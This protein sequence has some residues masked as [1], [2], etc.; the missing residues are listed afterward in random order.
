MTDISKFEPIPPEYIDRL[1]KD[2]DE[3]LHLG[4]N[5]TLETIGRLNIPNIK[6][7]A[8]FW[9]S[10]ANRLE[11]EIEEIERI[12]SFLKEGED[13]RREPIYFDFNDRQYWDVRSTSR[14]P[15][16]QFNF[17]PSKNVK[18]ALSPYENDF[19]SKN[20]KILEIGSADATSLYMP[21]G[22][23]SK[24]TVLD[25]SEMMLKRSKIQKKV[26]ADAS[27]PLPFTDDSFSAITSFA[28]ARYFQ[29]I[30][31]TIKEFE[32]IL[33]PAGRF[34]IVDFIFVT[35]FQQKAKSVFNPYQIRLSPEMEGFENV[36]IKQLDAG[37]LHEKEKTA[38]G[39]VAVY[40]API[41]ML[42]ATKK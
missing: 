26:Q 24:I 2:K 19:T 33:K 36:D 41:Y 13:P 30:P 9:N 29:D 22:S 10:Q 18:E 12:N 28:S 37:K 15:D 31:L 8:E 23:L 14:N 1:R 38:I 21:E 5:Q 25:I 16:E 32:R 6:G 4:D 17:L 34:V 3:A 27:E 39:T 20:A 40:Q 42:T 7:N 11:R 35:T